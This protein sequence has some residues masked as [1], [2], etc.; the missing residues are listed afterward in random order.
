MDLKG[1]LATI[2][3]LALLV[4]LFSATSF[5]PTSHAQSNGYSLRFYGHGVN[6]PDLDRVKIRVDDPTNNNPGPP[7]DVGA[8]DFT[9]EFW[10]KANATD[11]PAPAVS[12]GVNVNWITGNIVFD[13]DRYNQDRKFG[14]S[15]A[16]GVFVFGVSG[17]GTGDRTI[18]GTTNVLNSQWHHVAIERRRSDGWMWLYIDGT[19]QSQA[20]GP[21]GDISY[22]DNGVPGNFCGG[23]CT[24]SDPFL[25]IGAE[26][27]D[28][29]AQYPSYNGFLDEVRI[30]NSLRY[31]TNVSRPTMPFGTDANTVALYHLDEGPAGLCSPTQTIVDSSG[32]SGGPSNGICKPGGSAP[33]GP[34]YTTDTPFSSPSPTRTNLPTISPTLVSVN[35]PTATRTNTPVLPTLTRTSTPLLPTATRTN[36]PLSPTATRTST[37]L[38]GGNRGLQFNGTNS[39][40][41]AGQV[42]STGPLTIEAWVRPDLNN[43]NGLLIIGGDDNVGWS[44]ELANGRLTFW[45]STNLGWRSVQHPTALTAGQWYH[46]AATYSAGSARVFVN[47]NASTAATVG[48][49]TQGPWLR[50]GGLVGYPFYAGTLD[51]VRISNTLRYTANF[52]PSA[53]L[54]LDANT[55]SLWRFNE[56]TGQA[57]LDAAPVGNNAVLGTGTGVETSDPIW[58]TVTR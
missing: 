22:P 36:T 27:H 42:V 30:S 48:T 10:M 51:E 25:V 32:A 40:A 43:E 4:S 9:L 1:K 2:I 11:N 26:K 21:D 35:T 15:I 33:S 14:L 38:P 31:T 39:I 50:F 16:G 49:L 29:G 8:T 24:N 19:L 7:V 55:I 53:S 6:A 28:A 44:V 17:N 56:G 46:I 54:A 47:G 37:P 57:A 18:C 34:I 20:N 58:V 23:A 41:S 13:R 3:P 12:C 45:L 52:T 5:V